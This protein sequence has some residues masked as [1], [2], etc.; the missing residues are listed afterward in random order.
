[1]ASQIK[2]LLIR[3]ITSENVPLLLVSNGEPT[4]VVKQILV[5]NNLK[6]GFNVEASCSDY[7]Q[8]TSSV[9]SKA[10]DGNLTTRWGNNNQPNSWL[11]LRIINHN[12]TDAVTKYK[13]YIDNSD[14]F[15][16][17]LNYAPKDW[18][19]Q[20]SDDGVNWDDLDTQLGVVWTE[21]GWKEFSISNNH[22]YSYYRLFVSANNDS[23]NWIMVNELDLLTSSGESILQPVP[24]LFSLRLQ[25]TS[26]QITLVGETLLEPD[27]TFELSSPIA[28]VEGDMLLLH[29]DS[30]FCSGLRV[31]VSYLKFT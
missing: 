13:I 23:S 6:H 27:E 5:H 30:Q 25:R 2:N 14:S 28:I 21:S 8:P 11:Q 3:R 15:W 7:H 29:T 10:V 17:S 31:Y 4:C 16:N 19:F 12:F 1:M 18:H 24:N 26:G 20:G 22:N 9:A